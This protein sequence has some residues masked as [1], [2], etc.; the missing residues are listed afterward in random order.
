[1]D[2]RRKAQRMKT[3]KTGSVSFGVAAI[4]DCT[5][6]NMSSAG[7]CLDFQCRPV[8]PKDFSM[9]IKPDYIRRTCRVAW[10]S[11]SRVGV[12]FIRRR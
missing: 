4:V 1:M 7:A 2:E 11:E 6:R 3:L 8:L 5:I 12:E 9:V 10:Q